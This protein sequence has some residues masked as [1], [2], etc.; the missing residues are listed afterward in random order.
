MTYPRLNV[1]LQPIRDNMSVILHTCRQWNIEPVAVTKVHRAH[2]DIV[3]MLLELGYTKLGDSRVDNL[4]KLAGLNV[5]KLLIRIPMPSEVAELVK[6]ATS[7][8]ISSIYT[9]KL[10]DQEAKLQKKKIKLTLMYDIGDLREGVYGLENLYKVAKEID[11]LK[12]VELYGIG[13]NMSCMS[14]ILPSE[15]NITE[16]LKAKK[17]VEEYLGRKLAVASAGNTDVFAFL[18]RNKMMEG[19]NELRIGEGM[20]MGTDGAEGV[21]EILHQDAVTLEA[22][23]VEI[24]DKPSQPTGIASINPFGEK[25]EQ[26]DDRGMRKRAIVALGR[27]DVHFMHLIPYDE[28]IVL[29]GQ[30]SDHTVLDVADCIEQY[31]EGDVLKFHVKYG[32]ILSGFTSDYVYKNMIH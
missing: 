17:N 6:W 8:L 19:I 10:I 22:Q 12:N 24:Y 9:A 7:S 28:N 25:V 1:A 4:K 31:I 32:A 21:I 20:I 26:R 5:E 30:S 14:G 3:K 11:E 29:I 23:I 2:P 13:T 16:F 18:L 15:K 27:Q